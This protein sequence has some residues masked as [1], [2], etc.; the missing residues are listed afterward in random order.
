MI[1]GRGRGKIRPP[2]RSL[3]THDDSKDLET[4]WDILKSSLMEIHTKNASTLSF[5]QIYRASYKMVLKKQGD[6]LYD[7]VIKFEQDWLCSVTMPQIRTLISNNLVS[8]A[9]GSFTGVT[10]NERRLTGEQFLKGIKASWEDHI[11]ITNMTTDVLMYMDRVYCADNRKAS[12]F[13]TFMGLFRD[14]ILRSKPAGYDV[15]LFDILNAIILDQIDMERDGDVINKSLIRSCVY[16]LEGLY[17]TDFENADEKLYLTVFEV[18]YLKNSQKFYQKECTKLL[19][20]SDASTWL[21]QTKRRLEEEESRC[22][23][24]IS[25]LTAPKISKIIEAEMISAHISEFLAMEISGVKAMIENDR[26]EDLTLL[27][28]LLAR[29]D[30]LKEPLKIALQSRVV[31]LG[32]DINNNFLVADNSNNTIALQDQGEKTIERIEKPNS[33]SKSGTAAR[34]LTAAIRWVDEVLRLKDKFNMLW[35]QCLHKDLVLQTA[36]TKS[37]SQFINLFPRCSEYLSLFIDDNLKRGIKGK[38]ETEIDDLLDKAVTLLQ[39][40]HDKDMFE[41][42]YKK[43]L[44]RRLLYKKSESGDV[45]KQMISKM[46]QEIGNSFTTKIEGMFRDMTISDELTSQYRRHTQDSG[47]S[48]KSKIDLGINILT[49]NYWPIESMGGGSALRADRI[50]VPCIWPSE[51][52]FLQESFKRFY[53]KDRNG[54]QIT[55]LGFLGSAD[56]RCFFPKVAGKEGTLGRDRRYEIIVP[57][58]GMIVLLLFNNVA[59]CESLSFEEIQENTSIP[60]SDLSRILFTLSVP[61]KCKVLNKIPANKELPKPGDQFSFNATFTSKVMKIKAPVVVGGGVNSVEADDERK[62][63]ETRNDEHRGNVID[64]VI[65]RIMKT[66]KQLAHQE[67]F[68]ETI[69]QLSSRFKPDINLMKRRIESL[70]EREYIERVENTTV[71]TYQYLA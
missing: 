37:F 58:Y 55:W 49:T 48:N 3:T 11:M 4:Q 29:V 67:L 26:L 2:R 17:E 44:A 64:T 50:R 32:S 22:Q 5:E 20:S 39:Y 52:V 30:S 42:Y 25:I 41:R 21:R 31:E 66:R 54:R 27:Y 56:I 1:S 61:P 60:S 23:T 51:I 38:T 18:E 45:E 12:I 68:S 43:H 47:S 15:I 19:R 70:I 9:F 63:T 65:V 7:R 10:A 8:F 34:Q 13:T 14:H 33:L 71:P 35:E 40:I 36:I 53:L 59:D 62:E 69:S 24:T 46:K 6:Q 28:Q 57:T 16:M